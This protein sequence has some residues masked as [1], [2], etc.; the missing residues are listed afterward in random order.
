LRAHRIHTAQLLQPGTEIVL[1]ERGSHYL[2]RVLRLAPGQAVVLFN[3]DGH[4]Y[5]AEI[6]SPARRGM[7]LRVD[8]RLPGLPEPR[9]DITVAQAVSRGERM[10]QTLQKCTELGAAAFQLLDTERVEVRLGVGKLDKRM[11]HWRGVIVSA[12][13]QCGRSRVPGLLP[14][15]A[16][17]PWLATAGDATRLVLDPGADRS[18]ARWAADLEKVRAVQIV[19]GPEGGFSEGELVRMRVAGLQGVSLGPRVLRTE[20]AAP[21]AVAVLQALLGDL[22]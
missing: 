6:L 17:D 12:C 2:G 19:V 4:D 22:R 1:E 11:D 18:L 3:G 16:L 14:P 7:A 20:T 13:E 9:L 21:A 10:D 15:V 8:S 5:A